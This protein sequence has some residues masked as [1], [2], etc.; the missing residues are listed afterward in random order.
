MPNGWQYWLYGPGASAKNVTKMPE[1]TA[2]Q[3]ALIAAEYAKYVSE[4]TIEFAPLYTS[5]RYTVRKH[6]KHFEQSLTSD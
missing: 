1:P 3:T 5:L 2:A 4:W 6:M